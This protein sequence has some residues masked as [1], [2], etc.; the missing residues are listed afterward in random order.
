MATPRHQHSAA[1]TVPERGSMPSSIDTAGGGG[2][3]GASGSSIGRGSGR[4]SSRGDVIGRYYVS[5]LDSIT[6]LCTFR[7]GSF[8]ESS[9]DEEL[10]SIGGLGGGVRRSNRTFASVCRPV[11]KKRSGGG[12]SGS[13]RSAFLDSSQV[14]M[15]LGTINVP[16]S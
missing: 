6:S 13:S 8:Q 7:D 2:G 1:T 16:T 9:S 12:G 15:L 3:G 11:P 10:V 14:M 5:L 4:G